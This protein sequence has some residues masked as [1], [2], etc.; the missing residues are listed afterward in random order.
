MY[1]PEARGKGA[2]RLL[3]VET[4]SRLRAID[5]IEDI[6]LAVTV[7]NDSARALYTSAGFERSYIEPR[8]FKIDGC[9]YDIEWMCL[10]VI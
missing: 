1:L 7:G 5:G 2:G 9:Y 8:Y 4:V 6:I 10:R 3:L